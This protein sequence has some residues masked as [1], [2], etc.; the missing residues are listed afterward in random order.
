MI[1]KDDFIKFM[2]DLFH[3]S[4]S[5]LLTLQRI[6]EYKIKYNNQKE[7]LLSWLND[8]K[9]LFNHSERSYITKSAKQVINNKLPKFYDYV[10]VAKEFLFKKII[11]NTVTIKNPLLKAQFEWLYGDKDGKYNMLG[12]NSFYELGDY[13]RLEN[14]NDSVQY[15]CYNLLSTKGFNHKLIFY[16]YICYFKCAINCIIHNPV[17]KYMLKLDSDK[18]PSYERLQHN[19]YYSF[20]EY[21]QCGGSELWELLKC[22]KDIFDI[23]DF[24][25]DLTRNTY[26]IGRPGVKYYPHQILQ[27]LLY[28]INNTLCK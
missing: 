23:V 3:L 12:V 4:L 13:E 22:N 5:D 18:P 14:I 8:D 10:C 19:R 26:L 15:I 1:T 2:N 6:N 24:Y 11:N 21:V 27:E 25:N 16:S 9:V 7:D 17:F 28:Y 20:I